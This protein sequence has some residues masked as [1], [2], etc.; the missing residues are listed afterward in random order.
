MA[1]INATVS[2]EIRNSVN[3][4]NASVIFMN[5][6]LDK[7]KGYVQQSYKSTSDKRKLFVQIESILPTMSNSINTI[8]TCERLINYQ[9]EDLNDLGQL[10]SGKFRLVNTNHCFE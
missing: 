1:T 10:R 9:V 5:S 8:A 3:A 7:I 2:H 4:I 6:L